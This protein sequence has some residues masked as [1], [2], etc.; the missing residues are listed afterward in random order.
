M[1]Q[2]QNTHYTTVAKILHWWIA[3]LIIMMLIFGQGFDDSKTA[4]EMAFSLMGHSSLGLTVIGLLVLRILWR[5]GHPPPDLP[6]DM[7]GA[8]KSAAKLSHLMLYTLMIYVPLTGL[9][10][11]AVHETVATPFGAFNLNAALS[12]LGD[13]GFEG[14]RFLHEIGTWGLI[15]FLGLHIAAALQHQ[16]VLKDGVLRRMWFDRSRKKNHDA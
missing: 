14:R 5:L 13:G 7:N 12:F 3:V 4:D 6:E 15:G 2:P 16:F 11:I 10:T 1:N 9:Y 8:Q